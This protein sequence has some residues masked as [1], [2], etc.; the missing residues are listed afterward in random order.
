M[1]SLYAY[2]AERALPHRFSS[3]EVWFVERKLDVNSWNQRDESSDKSRATRRKGKPEGTNSTTLSESSDD[4][5]EGGWRGRGRGDVQA[6]A[7]EYE[8]HE[9]ADRRHDAALVGDASGSAGGSGAPG[10]GEEELQ[11]LSY[12]SGGRGDKD[13]ELDECRQ[14]REAKEERNQ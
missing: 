14:V 3:F 12:K 8:Q 2:G 13:G 11:Q 9:E 6:A 5:E 7:R 10:A 4:A 1:G